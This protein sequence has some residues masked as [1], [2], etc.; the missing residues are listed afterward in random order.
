MKI[1]SSFS[2]L[3]N[4]GQLTC[5]CPA[6]QSMA[7]FFLL[8][9]LLVVL[10]AFTSCRRD[11]RFP[12]LGDKLA[13]PLDVGVSKDGNYFYVVNTDLDRTYNAGSILVLDRDGKRVRA[14][15]T[16]RLPRS[17]TVA[18]NDMIVTVENPATTQDQNEFKVL[19]FDIAD[20]SSPN[21]IKTWP[22]PC[23]PVNA[24][25]R[26]GY[27]YFAVSC[28]SGGLL[29]GELT[30]DRAQSYIKLVREYSVVR[31]ALHIDPQRGL[32]FAFTT[33]FGLQETKDV[34]MP[35]EKTYD[36]NFKFVEEPNEV[37]DNYE[38]KKDA[39]RR[40]S[41]Y[42]Q[43]YQFVVYN[44]NEEAGASESFPYRKSDDPIYQ[45]ELRWLYFTLANFDGQPDFEIGVSDLKRKIYRTNFWSAQPDAD[46]PNAF[47]LSHRGKDTTYSTNEI[48]RV[49]IV[50]NVAGTGQETAPATADVLEFER[51]YGFKG[52]WI[53][54]HFP[55][56][57]L[58]LNINN[59]KTLVVNHFKDLVAW[60]RKDVYYSVAA[61]TLGTESVGDSI[62]H[63][64]LTSDDP[65]TS[66]YQIAVNQDGRAL[67]TSYYGNAVILLD[68]IPS[69]G[70]TIIRRI[71]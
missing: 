29:V 54:Q 9:N 66:F 32:L 10:G 64:E 49:S 57:F 2:M 7:Q 60:N 41:Y 35:D 16:P 46:D 18:G 21:L 62:W 42:R 70:I 19:L 55:C 51:V 27:K 3:S 48:V 63:Q 22:V 4:V 58:V 26:E 24:V 61:K 69:T 47:Y 52:E 8:I 31:R 71:E 53:P 6:F 40:P 67:M 5:G 30:S 50:G 33:D 28:T 56:S 25:L 17:I 34:D 59:Y 15:E 38:D 20:P 44:F 23:G 39:V 43:R 37:P 13:S 68:V 14:V 11:E 1:K 65:K 12:A 36:K 45:R